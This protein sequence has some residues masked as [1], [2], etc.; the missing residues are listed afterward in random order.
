L[1]SRWPFRFRRPTVN[2]SA[3]IGAQIP[4]LRPSGISEL[5]PQVLSSRKVFGL[6]FPVLGSRMVLG[7]KFPILS[8]PTQ[9]DLHRQPLDPIPAFEFRP[10]QID[11]IAFRSAVRPPR[12]QPASPA[13]A[14]ATGKLPASSTSPSRSVSRPHSGTQTPVVSL[15]SIGT[16]RSPV[17]RRRLASFRLASLPGRS[18]PGRMRQKT[19][20]TMKKPPADYSLSHFLCA[21]F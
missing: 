16:D 15:A 6:K 19:L 10:S 8:P 3:R 20:N 13:L 11:A 12:L 1:S 9:I 21:I 5:D 14:P 4:F 2:S 18:A 7:F 17:A